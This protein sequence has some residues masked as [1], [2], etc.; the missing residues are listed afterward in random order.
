MN[1]KR[2][3]YAEPI[4]PNGWVVISTI[5][6]GTDHSEVFPESDITP[7]RSIMCLEHISS[8]LQYFDVEEQVL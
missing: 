3:L 4:L 1:S 2:R 6:R 7:E 8:L 5:A